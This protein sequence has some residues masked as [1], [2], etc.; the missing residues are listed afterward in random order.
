MLIFLLLSSQFCSSKLFS[1]NDNMLLLIDQTEVESS[2]FDNSIKYHQDYIK[3]FN[4]ID[5]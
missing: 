5:I 2:L 4:Y 1:Q 3:G